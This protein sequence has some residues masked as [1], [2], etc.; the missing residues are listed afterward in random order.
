MVIKM[1]KFF[2]FYT[3][4][5]FYLCCSFCSNES[6]FDRIKKLVY[7]DIIPPMEIIDINEEEIDSFK[8]FIGRGS[9]SY[10]NTKNE[11]IM[12]R[13]HGAIKKEIKLKNLSN[14]KKIGIMDSNFDYLSISDMPELKF[15]DFLL[16]RGYMGASMYIELK[17][18]PKLET[19]FLRGIE[20]KSVSIYISNVP[21]LENIHF[22]NLQIKSLTIENAKKIKK[23]HCVDCEVKDFFIN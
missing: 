2:K 1:T 15:V 14:L 20:G 8:L 11:L 7:Q 19:L 22:L 10:I 17:N 6:E 12:I 4:I 23:F 5:L 13:Y 21:K 18:L 16:V 9:G 3:V